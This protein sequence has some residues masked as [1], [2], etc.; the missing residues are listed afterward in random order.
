MFFLNLLTSLWCCIGTSV[1]QMDGQAVSAMRSLHSKEGCEDWDGEN[2]WQLYKNS[3]GFQAAWVGNFGGKT[4][5][6]VEDIF[7]SGGAETE[8]GWKKLA[9]WFCD[10][11]MEQQ[12]LLGT[13]LHGTCLPQPNVA[14]RLKQQPPS[15]CSSPLREGEYRVERSADC[16]TTASRRNCFSYWFPKNIIMSE[17]QRE[18]PME[19]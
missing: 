10:K 18:T 17:I 8:A 1:F 16:Q 5:G 3:S 19:G 12:R 2:E 15:P 4:W 9:K 6:W 13:I 14:L 11:V 7:V